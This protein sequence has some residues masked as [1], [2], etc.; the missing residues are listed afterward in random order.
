[1]AASPER[2][3]QMV[4]KS[5]LSGKER[6]EW[7][8]QDIEELLDIEG[9]FCYACE[10]TGHPD[11]VMHAVTSV[12]NGIS[13]CIRIPD[14]EDCVETAFIRI[15]NWYYCVISVRLWHRSRSFARASI[16]RGAW[17]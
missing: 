16:G 14:K 1:M 11:G 9:V 3:C 12:D 15:F 10:I 17:L 2:C 6:I 13:F 4:E 5:C 8:V 7:S